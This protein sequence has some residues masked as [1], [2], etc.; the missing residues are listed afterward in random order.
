MRSRALLSVAAIVVLLLG[1]VS[2]SPSSSTTSASSVPVPT[3]VKPTGNPSHAQQVTYAECLQK[4]TEALL[5][6]AHAPAPTAT[7]TVTVT[8]TATPTP[9]PTPTATPTSTASPTPTPTPTEPPSTGTFPTR[10]SVGPAV[11]P[12]TAYA[13]DCYF[14]AAESGTV[15]DGKVVNCA[16]EGVR[17]AVDA[18]GI[19][20]R[21]S[22]I[23][24]MLFTIGNTAGDPGA[25][26]ASRAPV[27]TVEDSRLV[28][29][30]TVNA[31][32]RGACCS[33]YVIRRSLVQGTHSGL[34]VHNNA[35]LVGNY[36]T[37]DGTDSHS[38]GVRILKNTVLRG[39]TIVCKPVTPGQDGGCSAA[40][41]FYTEAL[42]GSG[43][44]SRM[45]NLTIEGNYF[46]RGV[47][48]SGASGGPWNA[49]RFND[50][51]NR[52]DCTG[53]EFTG[54]QFD[55]GWMTDGDE[56]PFYGG[57]VWSG[58][59]WADGQPALSGQSR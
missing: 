17:F 8:V 37:T 2:L 12:T 56:F 32:D 33:H 23:K 22:V 51:R 50:C 16:S 9:T 21:N 59:T 30:Q 53:L 4:R 39:N 48:A 36:I 3:C 19:V 27:F 43:E 10:T 14:S 24:G 11:E 41:V 40:G 20:F 55:L 58:N 5:A 54:N 31:Q 49:T 45:H 15:I 26:D 52:T 7:V 38:S 46:K 13:G 57:N 29:D 42:S 28:Q 1:L 25:E 47:T 34:A 35:E 18:T 44:P 6:N